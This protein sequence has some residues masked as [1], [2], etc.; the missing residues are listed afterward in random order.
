MNR[1][2]PSFRDLTGAVQVH[3]QELRTAGVGAV[4]KHAPVITA[5]KESL[6]WESKVFRLHSPLALLRAAFLRW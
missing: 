2:D 4:V 1:K 3:Y 6:L 5:E